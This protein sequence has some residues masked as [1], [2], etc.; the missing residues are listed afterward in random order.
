MAIQYI[1]SVCDNIILT[2][3]DKPNTGIIK[4]PFLLIYFTKIVH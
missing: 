4:I 1:T 3:N 2:I